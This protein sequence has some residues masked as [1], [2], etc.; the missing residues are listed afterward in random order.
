MDSDAPDLS[1]QQSDAPAAAP[2]ASSTSAPEA[3]PA[4]AAP[5][6]PAAAPAA[7]ATSLDAAVL[8]LEATGLKLD[9]PPPDDEV[10][11]IGGAPG[12]EAGA[13]T[14]VAQPAAGA[15]ASAPVT[16]PGEEIPETDLPDPTDA[17]LAAA[18]KGFRRRFRQ[19]VT[20]NARLK[21]QVA[22]AVPD[23]QQY[24]QLQSF[25]ATHELDARSAANAL[26][27]AALVQGAIN[28]RVDPSAAAAELRQWSDQLSGLVGDALPADLQQRLDEGAV[29]EAS[30][31]EIA[32]LR[33][34]QTVQARR[35]ELD[36]QAITTQTTHAHAGQIASAVR[37]WEAAVKAR[38][39]DYARKAKLVESQAVALRMQR[40]GG[41]LPPTVQEGL[42]LVQDAYDFANETVKGFMPASAA[43]RSP[44]NGAT[45]SKST[46]RA[47][48]KSSLEAAI[49][50]LERM[51]S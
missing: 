20:Q 2:A 28:G 46:M 40:Y 3:A 49:Q 10:V 24:R 42:K 8:G 51:A 6:A 30:A 25:M 39:P 33:A 12:G 35:A 36:A 15:E 1:S 44:L 5:A 14:P 26:R 43:V 23:A 19:V 17:E 29:D 21:E 13:D 11:R 48:P 27:I 37:T 32:K 47:E 45:P 34:V 38:D 16:P 4:A 41:G 22:Q 18:P 7:P 9:Q 50:G 31:K